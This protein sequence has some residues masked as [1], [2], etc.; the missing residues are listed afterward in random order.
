[1]SGKCCTLSKSSDG[2]LCDVFLFETDERE[3]NGRNDRFPNRLEDVDVEKGRIANYEISCLE[4]S[5]KLNV[6]LT[7]YNLPL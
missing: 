5:V 4:T 3:S 2:P 1:M 7:N 6:M